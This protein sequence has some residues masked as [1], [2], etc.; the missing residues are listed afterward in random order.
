MGE[1]R[2]SADQWCRDRE[3]SE[4]CS[5]ELDNGMR[6]QGE[7]LGEK[8]APLAWSF[9]VVDRKLRLFDGLDRRS[10]L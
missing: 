4:M 6:E 2:V 8:H 1:V 3:S 7:A 5:L 10:H 9:L